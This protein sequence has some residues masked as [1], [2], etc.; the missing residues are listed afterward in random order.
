MAIRLESDRFWLPDWSG[1]L[2]PGRFS[3]DKLF[4]GKW[5]ERNWRNAPGPLYGAQTD[6]CGT[7]HAAAPKNVMED[8]RGYEY[9]LIQP[10]NEKELADVLEAAFQD[11][12]AGYAADGNS[13]WTVDAVKDW[14]AA[15]PLI[16]EE[17]ADELYYK[18]P[19]GKTSNG[20]RNG[21]EDPHVRNFINYLEHRAA[22]PTQLYWFW[23]DN[24]RPPSQHESL[25]ELPKF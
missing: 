8:P 9:V 4:Y 21:D 14:W 6:N 5:P 22:R 13:H 24:G 12:H 20:F 10:C 25:P 17:L 23:L 3:D 19:P 1:E 7:G 15:R 16:L 11:P 18:L 2:A